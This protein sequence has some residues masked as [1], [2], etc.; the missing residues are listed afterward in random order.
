MASRGASRK[1]ARGSGAVVERC[2][3][4]FTGPT[5]QPPALPPLARAGYDPELARDSELLRAA[6]NYY[7]EGE[8]DGACSA[9]PPLMLRKSWTRGVPYRDSFDHAGPVDSIGNCYSPATKSMRL[10]NMPPKRRA[11][12][13]LYGPIG[14]DGQ[15]QMPPLRSWQEREQDRLDAE[16]RERDKK[17]LQKGI[18][19]HDNRNAWKCPVCK[20]R[21][22]KIGD[23]SDTPIRSNKM[24]SSDLHMETSD[25]TQK[26]NVTTSEIRAPEPLCTSN[27]DPAL[28]S[29]IKQEIYSAVTESMKTFTD[30]FENELQSIR[31]ELG[32]LKELKSA[33]EYLGADYD[34]IKLDIKDHEEKITALKKENIEMSSAMRDL[35]TRLTLMEQHCRENNLEITGIPEN[36][37][38]NIPSLLKQL[39][40]VISCPLQDSDILSCTR[41][42]KLDAASKR[43]RSIV[44]KLTNTRTRDS[45]LAAVYK[46][47]R[48]NPNE[49]L[50]AH[51][52]GYGG[53]KSAVY[54]SEH[55]CP[56]YKRL[57]AET[58]KLA[59]EKELKY[60]WIRNG[61]IFIRRNEES[62]AKQI[63]SLEDLRK[64]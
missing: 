30:R 8:G 61:R 37:S 53:D 41:V 51:L 22:P 27:L 62:Q 4:R 5:R 45:V 50:N 43:P 19:N 60:V 23:N 56:Y 20:S 40:T 10:I 49:K 16:K 25:A 32:I 1:R 36:K 26:M 15:P 35:S 55:L 9:F 42:R 17:K 52:L 47:N 11:P 3:P 59:R 12:P 44:V 57:H 14:P 39:G 33:V 21:Q 54:I 38:E 29:F 58:R 46:F 63:K 13:Q 34:S 2:P 24:E 7:P 6:K 18:V 64:L 48:A 31:S 28:L